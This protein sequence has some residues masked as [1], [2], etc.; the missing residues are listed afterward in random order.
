VRS[1]S[2]S[3]GSLTIDAILRCCCGENC[4]VGSCSVR[5][6]DLL[7]CRVLEN[8]RHDGALPCIALV[9][10]LAPHDAGGA[11]EQTLVAVLG[12][13]RCIEAARFEHRV[14]AIDVALKCR[15]YMAW[16]AAACLRW[17]L[18]NP[19]GVGFRRLAGEARRRLERL[20]LRM[21]ESKPS[22]AQFAVFFWL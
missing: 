14:D 2:L 12:Q 3:A 5:R 10:A 15:G 17:R 1:A 11:I 7:G 13:P 6:V 18:L 21:R 8:A 19:C 9:H 4:I 20:D 16:F 22:G